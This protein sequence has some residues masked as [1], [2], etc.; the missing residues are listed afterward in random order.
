[1]LK[2]DLEACEAQVGSLGLYDELSQLGCELLTLEEL[3]VDFSGFRGKAA[4][5]R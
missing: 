2:H 1:M 3:P 5:N 4:E